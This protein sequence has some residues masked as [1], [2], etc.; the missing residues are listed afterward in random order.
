LPIDFRTSV[1]RIPPH[2]GKTK[3]RNAVFRPVFAPLGEIAMFVD[4]SNQKDFSRYMA[5][6][7]AGLEMVVPIILGVVVDWKFGTGPWGAVVGAVV[8]LVMGVTHL[9]YLSRPK[10]DDQKPK[11]PPRPNSGTP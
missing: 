9:V 10:D 5:M 4:P 3:R 1:L 2:A 11:Q 8:G 7:Q 6:S